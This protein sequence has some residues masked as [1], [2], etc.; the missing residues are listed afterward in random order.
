MEMGLIEAFVRVVTE[1]SITRAGVTLQRNQ[2]SISMRLAALEQSLGTALFE[3]RG[4]GVVLTAAGRAFLPYAEKILELR[5]ESIRETVSAATP[6]GGQVMSLGANNWS[7]GA[8]LPRL[9]QD[10]SRRVPEPGCMSRCIPR[11]RSSRCWARARS[12]RRC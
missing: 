1:E 6:L 12:R 5:A 2:S 4:R 9:A 7:A 8:I 11:L 10:F 3:R